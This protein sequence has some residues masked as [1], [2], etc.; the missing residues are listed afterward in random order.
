MVSRVGADGGVGSR[1]GGA[2]FAVAGHLTSF[3]TALK[4]F[5]LQLHAC[6]ELVL[7]FPR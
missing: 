7:A 1:R 2:V 5:F 4:C 3:T 6:G